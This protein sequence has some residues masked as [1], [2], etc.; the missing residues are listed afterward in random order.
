MNRI[1][2]ILLLICCCYTSSAQV[3]IGTLD[4][5]AEL[6][7]NGAMLVQDAFNIKTLST[8]TNVEE[9]FKLI[10]RATNSDPIGEITVLNVDSLTVAPIN[11]VNYTFNNVNL[12]NLRNVDLSYSADNYIV[13]VAN[14]RYVGDAIE[15]TVS[16]GTNSIGAF[17]TRTFI[18][19]DTWHLEIR[20]RFLD[21]KDDDLKKITYHITLII[22]DKSYYRHLPVI[23]T[24]LNGS[25]TGTATSVPNF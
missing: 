22:Y 16:G 5:Q 11:V 6:D 10:T 8:V 13:G 24:D 1:T 4:P 7:V 18:E 25:N 9:N 19:A 12:D 3:G 23:T 17:V 15:K 14:F 2:L 20:N 21:L